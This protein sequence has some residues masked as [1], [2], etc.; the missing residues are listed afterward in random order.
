M[1]CPRCTQEMRI[2]K[3]ENMINNY[4]YL[5]CENEACEYYGIQRLDI[6]PF[7]KKK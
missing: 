3:E 4:D 7:K 5:Y 6:K 2:L 1:N